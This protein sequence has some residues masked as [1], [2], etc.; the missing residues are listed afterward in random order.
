MTKQGFVNRIIGAGLKNTKYRVILIEHLSKTEKLLSAKEIY[1]QLSKKHI[2]INL[3]TVYRTLDVLVDNNIFNRVT[4]EG[5]KQSRYEYNRDIH[6]HFLICRGCNKIIPI[7]DCPLE[8]YEE[9]LQAESGFQITGHRVEFY[10][11][12]DDCKKNLD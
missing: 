7:Y 10:G 3:S 5:E 11:F 9:R 1:K 8:V 4:I 6:H 12:C 2:A